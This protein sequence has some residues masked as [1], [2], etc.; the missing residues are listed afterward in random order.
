MHF[1]LCFFDLSLCFATLLHEC[2]YTYTID[3]ESFFFFYSLYKQCVNIHHYFF[4]RLQNIYSSS[5]KCRRDRRCQSLQLLYTLSFAHPNKW[6]RT[7]PSALKNVT[8]SKNRFRTI[9]CRGE[10]Y[11][12]RFIAILFSVGLRSDVQFVKNVTKVELTFLNYRII[13][14]YIIENRLDDEEKRRAK[15]KVV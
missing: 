8:S 15:L 10:N 1:Y 12:L 14:C 13:K 4:S 3:T 2:S 7:H 6:P 11:T 9:V 5:N